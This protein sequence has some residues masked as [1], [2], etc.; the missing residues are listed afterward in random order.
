MANIYDN[1]L[2]NLQQFLPLSEQE[3]NAILPQ[4]VT[5]KLAKGEYF[6]QEGKICRGVAY[7]EKGL[8]MYYT[9]HE[10]EVV[11]AEFA[12]ETK[13]LAYM[14][15]LSTRTPSDMNIVMLEEATLLT[16]SADTLE[17]LYKQFPKFLAFKSYQVE[18]TLIETTQHANNLARLSAKERYYKFMKDH[19]RLIDRIPQYYLAAYLGVTPQSISRIRKNTT[20]Q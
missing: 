17:N 8:A 20:K 4:V 9:L 15:S 18:K 19:P 11:P 6:L 16:L 5:K 2:A 7:V 1:F 12:A 14:K 3:I 10:G 13:W